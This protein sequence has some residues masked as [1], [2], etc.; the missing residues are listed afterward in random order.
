MFTKKVK[1]NKNTQLYKLRLCLIANNL[2][3]N[4]PSLLSL[5][6]RLKS[7]NACR[8]SVSWN[9]FELQVVSVRTNKSQT[10]CDLVL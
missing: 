2:M 4:L 6:Y 10:I 9:C 1:D 5:K 3:K 7:E 8:Y